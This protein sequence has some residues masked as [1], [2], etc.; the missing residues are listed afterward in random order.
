MLKLISFII[1]ASFIFQINSQAQNTLILVNGKKIAIGEYKYGDAYLTYKSQKGKLKSTYLDDVF[2]VKEQNG[3]EKVFYIPD[4]T[5]ANAFTVNQMRDFVNGTYDAR[6]NYKTPWIT[7]V[8]LIVGGGS[9]GLTAAGM[10]S[11]LVP[12]LPSFYSACIGLIKVKKEKLNLP[13]KFKNNEY[14]ME[15]YVQRVNH[16]RINHAILGSGAG[17]ALGI[18]AVILFAK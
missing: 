12:V 3:K 10:S 14:Y 13:A 2:A 1:F 18:V 15:G 9:A 17:I 4:S 16:K 5:E 7:S 11:L 6:T 8:G